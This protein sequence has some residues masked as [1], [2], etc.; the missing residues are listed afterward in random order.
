VRGFIAK[1][2]LSCGRVMWWCVHGRRRRMEVV[3]RAVVEASS[4][5]RYVSA[6]G[7]PLPTFAMAATDRPRSAAVAR[8][9]A[10]HEHG[11]GKWSDVTGRGVLF[12]EV[13][14][15]QARSRG[16]HA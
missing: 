6:L 4:E 8:A 13:A 16:M 14:A 7:H 1:D 12:R 11:K 15:E 2:L 3:G 9:P 5:A 10:V